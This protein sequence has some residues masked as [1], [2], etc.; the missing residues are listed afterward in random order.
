M[1]KT[2]DRPRTEAAASPSSRLDV[3]TKPAT[4]VEA[5]L[6]YRV[7]GVADLLD[8]PVA[9]DGDPVAHRQ[10][11][12]LVVRDED[13]GDAD[14]PLDLLELQLHRA[15][16]LEVQRAEGFV[17][18]QHLRPVDEGPGQ[19]HP[20]ALPAGELG[21]TALSVVGELDG[22]Q[23]RQGALAALAAGHL[24]DPQAVL[25]VGQHVHVREQRVVLEDGVD[26]ARE[27]R[28]TGDV[29]AVEADLPAGRLL[30][31]G[32]HPQH[33]RLARAG[34]SEHREEL[35]VLDG[36]VDAVDGP[37]ASRRTWSGRSA[38]L[39]VGAS[40]LLDGDGSPET[41]LPAR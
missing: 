28:P 10:R 16:Q 23:R 7:A 29:L 35:A 34:G 41:S 3:P 5:G 25:D 26:V 2:P 32:D 39:R 36:Q 37:H 33:G 30:E 1:L 27:R 11:L 31:A 4:N 22:L 40:G 24:L 20:L 14:L 15:A 38:R 21:G 12:L 9:E 13:E 6:S 18:E 17:E 8:A 19:R